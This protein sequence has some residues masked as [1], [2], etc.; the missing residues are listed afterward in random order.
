MSNLLFYF[1]LNVDSLEAHHLISGIL[2]YLLYCANE[3]LMQHNKL[4]SLKKAHKQTTIRPE[5]TEKQ[6]D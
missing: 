6:S 2:L 3:Y 4:I 1:Q 5:Q